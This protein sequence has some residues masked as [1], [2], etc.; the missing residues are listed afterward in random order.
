MSGAALAL[1]LASAAL[2]A[3]WNTLLA[4]TEDT[5]ASTAV[6]LLAAAVVFAPVAALTW[7]VDGAAVPYIAASAACEL[8]YFALLA[9]AYSR[10][11]LTF[12]YPVARGSAP[13]IVL[14]VSVTALGVALGVLEVLG[15]LAV[16][17]GVL[18][19]RGVGHGD[20]RTLAL[21]LGVGACIASYTLIDDHGL[22]HADAIP[23]FEVVL[24]LMAIPYAA[25]VQLRGEGLRPRDDAAGA[26]RRHRHVRRLR[27]R[28]L[29]PSSGPRPRRWRRC[30]RRA[31]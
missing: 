16:A 4:D 13:V 23:Y 21:A 11:G 29:S 25:A 15:V 24:V 18:L 19:V 31:S 20:G 1:V 10:A 14:A 17:G 28:S 6:A 22:R 5:H 30:A 12:V 8:L 3:M 26:G 7:D 9:T 2:H 27:A